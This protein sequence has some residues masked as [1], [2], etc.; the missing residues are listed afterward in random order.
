MK[1]ADKLTAAAEFIAPTW[2]AKRH[3]VRR[4]RELQE[5]LHK[6]QKRLIERHFD[7]AKRDDRNRADMWLRSRMSPDAFL[8]SD[9][10]DMRD[11]ADELYRNFSYIR[12]A[13]DH[14]TDNVVGG[15]LRAKAAIR[16]IDGLIT[17]E[18]AKKWNAKLDELYTLWSARAGRSGRQSMG[19]VQRLAHKTWRKS[20][21]SVVVLS[22]TPQ[23]NKP[24]TLQMNVIDPERL[25]TPND[26]TGNPRI[27]HGI[28]RNDEGTIVAYYIRDSH[29]YDTVAYKQTWTAYS[30]DR[31]CHLYE[32]L[33]PDQVRGL[34]WCFPVITDCRDFQ[35]Y[36][37]A[38]LIAAQIGACQGYVLQ[39]SNPT[40]LAQS[41]QDA[42]GL[43]RIA[44]GSIPIVDETTKMTPFNPSQPQT[45]Y[46]QFTDTN[47]GGIAAGLN[48]PKAWITRDRSRAT[49]SAG[50]LEER[51]G[52]L[53]LRS[54]FQT[55]RDRLI[56][57]TWEIF[58]AECHLAG[59][60]DFPLQLFNRMPWAFSRMSCLPVGRQFLDPGKEI[61]ALAMAVEQNFMTKAMVHAILGYDSD[62]IYDER[63]VEV[64]KEVDRDIVPPLTSG[65]PVQAT[66]Q[67]DGDPAAVSQG[68]EDE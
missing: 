47:L 42:N 66:N 14:R 4:H 55:V 23:P 68:A 11:H 22:D 51:E 53:A 1:L 39:T 28:E 50:K 24:I 2:A 8:E 38:V 21:D 36:K 57:P 59:L 45:T 3:E 6:H 15:G 30:A 16:P 34:P 61:P 62:E 12:G 26:E 9:L 64:A 41:Q 25:S 54:D 67:T 46:P 48:T 18:Q 19:E 65:T 58:V 27:R 49:F 44:P 60:V 32:E 63:A 20:G 43:Q 56:V 52:G 29:P 5:T 33:W 40:L 7:A 31:V 35:D 13:I 37:E 10:D 17:P